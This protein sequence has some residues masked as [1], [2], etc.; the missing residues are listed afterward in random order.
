MT[1]QETINQSCGLPYVRRT[2]ADTL[3]ASNIEV[4]N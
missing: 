2:G 3:S 4:L 1:T